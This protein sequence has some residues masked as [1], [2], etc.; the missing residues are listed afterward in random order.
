[1]RL[2]RG[3]F[4]GPASQ[5]PLE[6]RQES[7]TTATPP[8]SPLQGVLRPAPPNTLMSAPRREA[9]RTEKDPV[10]EHS[11]PTI[12]PKP[13]KR[14]LQGSVVDPFGHM[15][16]LG[17]YWSSSKPKTRQHK[18]LAGRARRVR[19]AYGTCPQ[20][21]KAGCKITRGM[22]RSVRFW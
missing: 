12:G 18:K 2:M 20:A 14:M 8:G 13:I 5:L 15:W 11:Y 6:G 4:R 21:G 19:L 16:L 7:S 17:R 3:R 10:R 1:M 22:R 9:A